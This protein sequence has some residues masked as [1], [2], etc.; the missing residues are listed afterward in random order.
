MDLKKVLKIL[1][2]CFI[3][4]AP[5][6]QSAMAVS[7]LNAGLTIDLLNQKPDPVKPGD[8]LEVSFS[9]QNTGSNE[10]KN[11]IVE[12]VPKYPFKE[13][14]GHG[15]IDNI[16]TLGKRYVDER[17]KVVKFEVLVDNN[18]N[19]GQYPLEVQVYESG[20]KDKVCVSREFNI[21][22]D[23]ESNAEIESLSLEKLVPGK[24]TNMSFIIKNV[25]N[26]PLKNAMF[27]WESTND[28]IL[29]V[30]SSNVKYINFIDVDENVTVNFEVM[31]NVNTVPGLYKLDMKLV[32]DDVEE[33]KTITEAGTLEN[34]KRK[35]IESKAGIYVGGTT[36]FDIVFTEQTATG[37]YSFSV[38]NI[39]NNKA[40]SITVSVPE[41][42]GWATNGGSN[43]VVVGS[44]QKGDYTL[45]DF[46]LTPDR[47]DE[48]LPLKF[49]ISYTSSDGER[50]VQ[51][52]ELSVFAS[53]PVNPG[54]SAGKSIL[55]TW[56]IGGLLIIGV[57]GL[58]FYKKKK[59]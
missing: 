42:E 48:S 57:A 51:D 20:K 14:S 47:Y 34:Q 22:I 29:P 4:S 33:L 44:L 37:D 54:K 40:N 15:L 18:V 36:E 58:L 23:S 5:L 16:G 19:K 8:V 59:A 1:I 27:S 9:I 43:S 49:L 26:S 11:V 38:S 30:G 28:I 56:L 45:T 55:S 7:N 6:I 24:K 52:K 17:S 13:I 50:N 10:K 3:V 53:E 39:G 12:L 35:T 32:Y 46:S 41:Q 31:T 2:L 21:Y 25:G